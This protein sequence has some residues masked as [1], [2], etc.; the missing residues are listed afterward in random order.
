M[1]PNNPE[2]LSQ[3]RTVLQ[4]KARDN[5]R[6]PVQWSSAPHGGFTAPSS[7]PWMRVNDDYPTINVESQLGKESSVHSFWQRSLEGR[8]IHKDVFV[9]GDFKL[10]DEG[11]DQVV[12]YL[13][14]SEKE[15]FITVLNF[16]GKEA[17]WGG[18]GSVTVQKWVAGNYEGGFPSL[19]TSKLRPWEGLL[20]ICKGHPLE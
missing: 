5:A 13:R 14:W 12:V 17:E 10:L 4:K 16:S 6:T 18:L 15:M 8:K 20:G 11:N 7:K 1:Y 9:Y 2:K 3:A 19:E